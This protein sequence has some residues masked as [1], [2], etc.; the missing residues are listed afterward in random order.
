VCDPLSTKRILRQRG[1]RHHH[2]KSPMMP[3]KITPSAN[4]IARR[5][6]VGM[7]T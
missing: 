2:I 4:Q 6:Q 7:A 1:R 3:S 5:S